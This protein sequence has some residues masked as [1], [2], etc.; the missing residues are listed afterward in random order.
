MKRKYPI[1][2]TAWFTVHQY[3]EQWGR[4]YYCRKKFGLWNKAPTWDHYLAKC[5]GGTEWKENMVL[6]CH[7]CNMWKWEID[8]DLFLDWYTQYNL[9]GREQWDDNLP[10][11]N[12]PKK[13]R[14]KRMG[15]HYFLNW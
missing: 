11:I 15:Y 6:C 1:Q 13:M 14:G 7:K 9:W 3:E 10:S 2:K 5:R 8:A 4:C 12:I